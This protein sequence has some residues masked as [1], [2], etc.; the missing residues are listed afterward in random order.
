MAG[1]M[2]VQSPLSV[3]ELTD[4]EKGATWDPKEVLEA[5]ESHP[6]PQPKESGQTTKTEGGA[7][8][9]SNSFFRH[10]FSRRGKSYVEEAAEQKNVRNFASGEVE[11]EPNSSIQTLLSS[12]RARDF[13]AY[14][15]PTCR[16]LKRVIA[17]RFGVSESMVSVEN[18]SDEIVENIPRVFLEPGE[19]CLFVVPTFF[20][21]IESCQ[22]MK[23]AII[24]IATREKNSFLMDRETVRQIKAS[25]R[26]HKPRIIWL[27]SPNSVSGTVIPLQEIEEIVPVTDQLVVVDETHHELI[28]PEDQHSAISLLPTHRNLIVLRSVSKAFGLAGIR[29]GFSLSHPTIASILE[30]WRL[31]FTVGTFTQKIAQ[32]ALSDTK[33]LKD[34]VEA[35]TKLRESVFSEIRALPGFTIG[36][37]SKT[38]LF[39]LK[40]DRVDLFTALRD[41]GILAADMRQA[42]G[43]EGKGYVRL[44][45]KNE[46]AAGVLLSALRSIYN[47]RTHG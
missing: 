17:A 33:H 1:E 9:N 15:D 35:V 45:I 41:R 28:D 37:A 11:Q 2:L 42:P 47:E 22:K 46:K 12:L 25:V 36:A 8:M 44:N 43:L 18:G 24:K 38:H 3:A 4:A 32:P 40:H 14:P 19:P 16:A 13:V 10:A 30:R 29:F 39:L 31:L 34:V 7:I 23:G 21:F 26:K 20:R 6:S 27:D 5:A